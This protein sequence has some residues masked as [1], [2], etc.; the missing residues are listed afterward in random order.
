MPPHKIK[1]AVIACLGF[2]QL[3]S[4]NA[5]L[6]MSQTAAHQSTYNQARAAA[7]AGVW[8][9]DRYASE[10]YCG[11]GS[12]T[13]TS[14]NVAN[15]KT[16]TTSTKIPATVFAGK[17]S[18]SVA[19]EGNTTASGGVITLVSTGIDETSVV[20][21]KATLG[22]ATT[23]VDTVIPPG[24]YTMVV[25]NNTSNLHVSLL[26]AGGA[27][28]YAGPGGA[29]AK[30][31]FVDQNPTAGDWKLTVGSGGIGTVYSFCINDTPA[32]PC[33]SGVYIY[34]WGHNICYIQGS[35]A[36]QTWTA[37]GG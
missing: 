20:T 23:A 9:M 14:G 32:P 17:T 8:A 37:W 21:A 29:G 35:G 27:G 26:G 19:I 30:V 4:A 34:E 6:L 5:P 18:F 2:S 15:L 12:M 16:I 22:F 25:P 28:S 7:Q 33:A 31:S 24:T 11:N 13:C 36:G 1:I 10:V 3:A